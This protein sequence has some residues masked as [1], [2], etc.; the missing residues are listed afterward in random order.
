MGFIAP[1]VGIISA[2]APLAGSLFGGGGGQ[3]APPPLQ[4]LPTPP[5]EDSFEVKERAKQEKARRASAKGLSS[6]ILTG[7]L[8]DDE[9]ELFKPSLLGEK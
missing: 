5:T 4:P 2:I 6:T 8:D 1:I 7:G 3:Q 9:L